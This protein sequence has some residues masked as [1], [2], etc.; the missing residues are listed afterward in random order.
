VR[1]PVARQETSSSHRGKFARRTVIGLATT[2]LVVATIVVLANN[3][4]SST[5]VTASNAAVSSDFF[6]DSD[7]S[8]SRIP[9]L[10][11]SDGDDFCWRNSRDYGRGVGHTKRHCENK[12]GSGN[13]EKSLL[14]WY[15]KCRPG[16]TPVACCICKPETAMVPEGWVKCGLGAATD[17][18]ACASHIKKQVLSVFES[19]AKIAGLVASAGTSAAAEDAGQMASKATEV[20]DTFSDPTSALVADS[21][22]D[23]KETYEMAKK[24]KEYGDALHEA[25]QANS[26]TEAARAAENA[27]AIVDPTGLTSVASAYTY[28]KCSDI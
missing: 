2:L 9:S 28:P 22:E 6:I 11:L 20:L 12:Y 3:G 18:S 8:E 19:I 17:R 1:I 24:A 27:A 5:S 26:P 14:L 10:A 13:C 16:F 7:A 15:P 4:S 23:V 25:V 21:S